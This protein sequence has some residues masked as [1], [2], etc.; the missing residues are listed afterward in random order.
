MAIKIVID[1]ASDIDLKEAEALGVT[2]IPMEIQFG[3]EKYEDG[4]NLTHEQFFEKLIESAELPKTSQINPYTFEEKF[5]PLV[6][7]GHEVIAITI[8]SKLSGTFRNAQTAAKKFG[9]QVTVVDSLNASIGE[10]LLCQYALRLI[11]DGKSAQEIVSLL[12][13]AKKKINLIAVLDTLKYLKKGG[14]IGALTAFA[15][16]MLSIKPVI[17]IIDGAVK[18]IGKAIGS[19]K[20]NNLLNTLVREKGIDFTMP[21]GVIWSGLDDSMLLK[22]LKDSEHLWRYQ[23]DS[24]PSYPIGSTIGTHIG[25]GGI[26]VAFFGEGRG[27]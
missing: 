1:S 25:P 12:N 18:L 20:G 24:V 3:D 6:E 14:R 15:G 19:K 22:Y 4:V 17:G 9:N 27:G 13:E 26:G 21:Y 7:E 10:R 23:T 5:A 2:L 11:E 16:E 8:S